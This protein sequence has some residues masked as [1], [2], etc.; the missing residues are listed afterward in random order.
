MYVPN[1][2]Y[3]LTSNSR[4]SSEVIEKEVIHTHYRLK[5]LYAVLVPNTGSKA[6]AEELS[7]DAKAWKEEKE[8]GMREVVIGSSEHCP[9]KRRILPE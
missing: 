2:G 5:E 4:P 9:L 3:P 8:C 7:G 6:S 1:P